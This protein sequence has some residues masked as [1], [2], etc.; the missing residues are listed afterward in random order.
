MYGLVH[1]SMYT[2]HQLHTKHSHTHRVRK[3]GRGKRDYVAG[4]TLWVQLKQGRNI[5]RAVNMVG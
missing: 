2:L 4:E 5:Q 1:T 3:Y